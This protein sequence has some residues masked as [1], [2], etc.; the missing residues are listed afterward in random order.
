MVGRRLVLGDLGGVIVGVEEL[1]SVVMKVFE[2]LRDV[3]YEVAEID[4][5][6]VINTGEYLI[7][8]KFKN[9]KVEFKLVDNFS[10][11]VLGFIETDGKVYYN[12]VGVSNWED[13]IDYVGW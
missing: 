1:V 2:L 8:K 7:A 6:V 10:G 12:V 5:G 13:F 11:E 9:G 4:D 3:A